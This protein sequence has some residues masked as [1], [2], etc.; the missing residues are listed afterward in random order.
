MKQKKGKEKKK[1]EEKR[2][3]AA[4]SNRARV[5]IKDAFQAWGG[6]SEKKFAL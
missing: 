3:F 4:L 5:R 2:K 1:R 6:I